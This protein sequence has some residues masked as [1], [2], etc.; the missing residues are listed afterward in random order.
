MKLLA[1]WRIDRY[2]MGKA[3]LFDVSWQHR[4][5]RSNGA[6]DPDDGGPS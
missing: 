6:A 3:K 1:D 2:Y 4:E 5:F